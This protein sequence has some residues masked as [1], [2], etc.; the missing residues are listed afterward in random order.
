M[1]SISFLLY[2]ILQ[3]DIIF[4]VPL[5][6]TFYPGRFSFSFHLVLFTVHVRPVLSPCQAGYT[7]STYISITLVL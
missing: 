2:L 7:L 4:M 3:Y 6:F 5:S 1:G